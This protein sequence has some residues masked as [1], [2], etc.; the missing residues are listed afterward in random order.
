MVHRLKIAAS[1]KAFTVGINNC[2][3]PLKAGDT[4]S[5]VVTGQTLG[6][7]TN[8]FNSTGTNTGVML[9]LAATPTA[10]ISNGQKLL[11][12]TAGATPAV[13]DFNGKSLSMNAAL[14]S[15]AATADVG[16]VNAPVCSALPIT[17]FLF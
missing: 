10:Y 12:A 15:S 3:A 2:Q 7:N 8:M 6:G 4:A 16:A 17:D 14:A 5:M 11:L 1:K 13:G 9:S